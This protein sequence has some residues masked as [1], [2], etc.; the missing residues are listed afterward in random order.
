ME[1]HRLNHSERNTYM[2]F[3]QNI[4]SHQEGDRIDRIENQMVSGMPDV[5]VCFSGNESWIEI[6]SPVEPKRDS[7]PLFGSNHKLSQDQMNWI[8][9]QK[10]AGGKSYVL[11]HTDKRWMLING[12]NADMINTLTV[13]QLIR[14]AIW[15]SISPVVG[16][17]KWKKLK[18][19]IVSSRRVL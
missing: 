12:V 6:K 14:L 19:S 1:G 10:S 3:R 7:T 16:R 18:A 8:K 9:R 5:N 13:N 4:M 2:I 17:E 11:I 15:E